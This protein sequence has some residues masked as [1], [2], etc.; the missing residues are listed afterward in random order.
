MTTYQNKRI[1]GVFAHPDDE[2]L[3]PGGTIAH[4]ALQG[5]EVALL[6]FTC[7]EAGSIGVSKELDPAEL[8]RRRREELA[9]SCDA[10]GVKSHR[11]VGAPDKGVSEYDERAAVGEILAEIERVR[12]QVLLTFHHL[13]VSGHPDHIA[14]ASYLDTAFDEAGDEGPVKLYQW[15]IPEENSKL[16]ERPNLMTTPPQEVHAAITPSAEA[17]DR[18]I[19]AIEQHVTQINFFRSLETTFDYRK[20]SSPEFFTLVKT[21]LPRPDGVETDLFNGVD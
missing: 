13:G 1:L 15:G 5:V 8:C 12:P 2:C 10:L 19:R 14:V 4:Y 7:G 16:Y 6:I 20:G 9:G 18:K 21:R 3:G 17:M 11:I